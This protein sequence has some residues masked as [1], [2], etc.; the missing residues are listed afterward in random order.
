MATKKVDVRQLLKQQ[1]GSARVDHKVDALRTNQRKDQGAQQPRKRQYEGEEEREKKKVKEEPKGLGG[2]MTYDGS[3]SEDEG[4]NP[5]Q[6][7]DRDKS[8]DVIP[9][10]LPAN[11]VDKREEGK[12]LDESV[13]ALPE[14]FFDDPEMDAKIRQVDKKNQLDKE[15]D[16]FQQQINVEQEIMEEKI[17]EEEVQDADYRYAREVNEQ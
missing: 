8:N 4:D 13:S 14:G 10:D 12:G 1:T 15:W 3:S 7:K 5:N 16:S 11:G 17:E 6:S 9:I 2:L